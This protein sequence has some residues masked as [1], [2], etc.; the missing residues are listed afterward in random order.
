MRIALVEDNTDLAKGIAYRMQDLGHSVDLLADGVSALDHLNGDGADVIILDINLPGVDGLTVLRS[1]RAR[2]DDR[3]VLLLTARSETVD[4]VRGLDA[5]A[6]DYLVKPFEMDE[7]EAR[8]RALARRQLRP[9]RQVLT[10]GP[11]SLDLQARQ[12]SKNG[13]PFALPRR[14]LSLLEALMGAQGRVLAK[15]D[16]MDHLYGLGADIEDGAVEVHASRLR[17]R[18]KPLGISIQ[19]Q[20]GLGYSI[21]L[22]DPPA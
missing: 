6:D 9:I 10:L 11:L 12:A 20:R 1:L 15:A 17:K 4:R 3:P 5:G 19:V 21:A 22:A 7:L 14:E 8:V 2:G 18:L 16:L 13:C